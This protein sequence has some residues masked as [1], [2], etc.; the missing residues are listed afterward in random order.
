MTKCIVL[1]EKSEESKGNPIDFCLF[2]NRKLE[3]KLNNNIH[4]PYS[5]KYIELICLNYDDEDNDI[6]FAYDDPCARDE[7]VLCIGHWND[8]VV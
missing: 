5:F 1:G 2:L 8:G 4:T 6:M 3:Y 7:G